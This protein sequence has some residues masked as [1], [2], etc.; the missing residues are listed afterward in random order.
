[1]QTSTKLGRPMSWKAANRELPSGDRFMLELLFTSWPSFG[2]LSFFYDFL[3]RF[4]DRRDLEFIQMDTDSN[5]LAISGD[6]LEDVI[7]PEMRERF[8]KR[9]KSS[10]SLG[11]SGA[12]ASRGFSSWNTLVK[13]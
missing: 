9:K 5:Y 12:I 2:C 8:S 1:M 4:V 11:T 6:K 7:K 3:D 13:E 10:G